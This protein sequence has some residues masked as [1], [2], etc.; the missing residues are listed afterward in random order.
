L[1]LLELQRQRHSE[2]AERAVASAQRSRGIADA[3]RMGHQLAQSREQARQQALSDLA[4]VQNDAILL[5]E[6]LT[7]AHQKSRLQRI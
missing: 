4:K 6:E 7:K 2:S 5:R 1:R 3:Q